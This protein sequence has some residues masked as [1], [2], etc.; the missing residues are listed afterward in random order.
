MTIICLILDKKITCFESSKGSDM[1]GHQNV[2]PGSWIIK[3]FPILD[4]TKCAILNSSVSGD[5]ESLVYHMKGL[6]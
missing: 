3:A 4:V 1:I 5:L 2:L 6:M